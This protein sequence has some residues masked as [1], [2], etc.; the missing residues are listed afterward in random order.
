[1]AGNPALDQLL[2]FVTAHEVAHQWWNA[3][4]GS[5]SKKYPFIDEAMAN[6]SAILYFEHEYGREAAEQQMALQ[7]KLNYQL[8]RML[9]GQDRPVDQDAAAFK[10]P[11]EYS[12]IVYGKGALYFDEARKLV[13]DAAFFA[14][15]RDY[16]D[17]FW[18]RIAGPQDF[19]L[20]LRDHVPAAQQAAVSALYR[21]WINETHGDQDIG[22]GD[23]QS[24]M[25]TLLKG[26]GQ[27]TLLDDTEQKDLL[28]LLDELLKE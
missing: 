4:V 8:H 20:V 5:N 16:Y 14:A 17:R 10:G 15:L 11:L 13:G 3:V 26:Q 9:G 27:G 12:A 7:M 1:M 19:T 21:H 18:F 24:L 6:Y 28:K 25:N 22:R 23:L 2:E